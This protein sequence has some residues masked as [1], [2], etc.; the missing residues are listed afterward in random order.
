MTISRTTTSYPFLA[1]ARANGLDY[2]L[3]LWLAGVIERDAK[4]NGNGPPL[5]YWEREAVRRYGENVDVLR[6]LDHAA[7]RAEEGRANYG[8]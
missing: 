7:L 6:L 8:K 3:V 5:N 2:G 4:T 1:M